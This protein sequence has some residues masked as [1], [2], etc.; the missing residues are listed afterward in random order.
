[1]SFWTN[2]QEKL[3]IKIIVV[4]NKWFCSSSR[5]RISQNWSF[6]LNKIIFKIKISKSFYKF[7]S[8]FKS[9]KT[10]FICYQIKVSLSVNSFYISKSVKFFWKWSYSFAQNLKLF[11]KNS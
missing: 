9:F 4:S 1:M 2:P 7:A 5:S 6:Y 8:Q 11:Y 10:F 3:F